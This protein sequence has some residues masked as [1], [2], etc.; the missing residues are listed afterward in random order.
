MTGVRYR[1]RAGG[2]AAAEAFLWIA[3]D[4]L[5]AGYADPERRFRPLPG[6]LPEE[7]VRELLAR[8]LAERG[9]RPELAEALLE[10]LF[11]EGFLAREGTAGPGERGLLLG[12]KGERLLGARYLDRLLGAR[13]LPGRA[14]LGRHPSTELAPG[15]E[16][17]GETRPYRPGEPL[18]LDAAETLKRLLPRPLAELGEE[19][20]VQSLAEAG[21]AMATA[22]LLD[23]SHSMVLYDKDRFTPA[24]KVALALAHLIR[25]RFPGDRLKVFCFGDRAEEVPPA[26]LALL[27]V[28]PWH[29]NTAEALALAYRFLKRSPEPQKQAILITDGKPSALTLPDGSV[30]KNAWGLDERI[31]AATLKEAVRLRRLGASLH[32]FMLADHPELVAFVRR[33]VA[34]G[35][36]RAIL[37]DPEA[38]GRHVLLDFLRRQPSWA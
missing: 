31:V 1:K 20:L 11:E 10:R 15:V 32:V 29:T 34:A 17:S 22:L 4:L 24:K 12:S 27:S 7:R 38:L 18:A 14:G 26:K 21:R 30:Y 3:E 37:T 6:L 19:H 36:G 28:G 33:L 25:T 5:D 2:P 35:R 8:A 16:A 23:C 9:H 13:T